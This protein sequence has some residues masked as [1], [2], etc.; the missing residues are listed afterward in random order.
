[1]PLRLFA[2]CTSLGGYALTFIHG[3]LVYWGSYF[4]PVYFQAVRG[5]GGIMSEVDVLPLAAVSMPFS[6]LVAIFVTK[7]GHYREGSSTAYWAGV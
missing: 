2:N 6:I 5:T 1:M 4:L 7:S 3:M